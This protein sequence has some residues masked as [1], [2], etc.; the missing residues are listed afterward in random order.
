MLDEPAPAEAFITALDVRDPS[1]RTAGTSPAGIDEALD[2][3]ERSRVRRKAPP[4]AHPLVIEAEATFPG[5]PSAAWREAGGRLDQATDAG[6]QGRRVSQMLADRARARSLAAEVP[7]PPAAPGLVKRLFGWL[8]ERMERLLERLRPSRAV[9]HEDR[10]P[11]GEGERARAAA[12]RTDREQ[13]DLAGKLIA[14]ARTAARR[15]GNT[16]PATDTI[17]S[18][19]ASLGARRETPAAQRAVLEQ[20]SWE[21]A[22]LVGRATEAAHLTVRCRDQRETA[23]DERHRQALGEWSALPRRRRWMTPRPERESPG[24]PSREDVAAARGQLLGVVTAAMFA[25]LERV[26]PRPRPPAAPTRTPPAE[27]VPRRETPP[28]PSRS[29][30]SDGEVERPAEPAPETPPRGRPPPPGRGHEPS[31]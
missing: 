19:A 1:W 20:I 25:E 28:P 11:S 3:A 4:W 5:A 6:R 18:A 14:A 9:P 30:Q 13:R 7:E 8:R 24:P 29:R 16:V 26:M 15:W 17:V 23:A 12:A 21:T 27:T 22:P 31:F 10:S 2:A